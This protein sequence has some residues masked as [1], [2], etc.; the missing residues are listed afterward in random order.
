LIGS[1]QSLLSILVQITRLCG[2]W[3]KIY[4]VR[5]VLF[6]GT[7]D[8]LLIYFCIRLTIRWPSE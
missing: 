4:H 3:F 2:K 5:S 8:N 7:P 6:P 1:R